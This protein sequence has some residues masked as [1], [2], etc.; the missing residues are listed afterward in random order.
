M[1]AGIRDIVTQVLRRADRVPICAQ[2][3]RLEAP[4]LSWECVLVMLLSR[5]WSYW[6]RVVHDTEPNLVSLLM[7]MHPTMNN[8][9][10][11]ALTPS[12]YLSEFAYVV[13]LTGEL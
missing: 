2:G 8:L 13:L 5:A 12:E 11:S 3:K 6:S 10:H 9:S 7:R 1:V 4:K